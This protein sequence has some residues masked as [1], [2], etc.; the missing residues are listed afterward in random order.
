MIQT[1]PVHVGRSDDPSQA[2]QDLL[3]SLVRLPLPAQAA[4]SSSTTASP[5]QEEVSRSAPP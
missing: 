3:E 5:A 1:S 2:L 4:S